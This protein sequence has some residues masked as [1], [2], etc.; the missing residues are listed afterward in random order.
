MVMIILGPFVLSPFDPP[1]SS[2]HEHGLYTLAPIK[3][4]TFCPKTYVI[5]VY[6]I[7]KIYVIRASVILSNLLRQN[8]PSSLSIL[9]FTLYHVA[10]SFVLSIILFHYVP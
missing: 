10:H 4:S 1:L 3:Y 5:K 6:S 8:S 7:T 9:A 2:P